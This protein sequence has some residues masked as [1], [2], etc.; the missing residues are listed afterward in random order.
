MCIDWRF[1][2]RRH[3]YVAKYCTGGHFAGQTGNKNS[4]DG[5]LLKMYGAFKLQR[6]T[7][8]MPVCDGNHMRTCIVHNLSMFAVGLDW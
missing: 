5:L 8:E 7:I 3:A 4:M 2:K 6:V 1:Q